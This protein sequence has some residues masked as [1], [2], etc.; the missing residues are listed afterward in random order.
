MRKIKLTQK[1][2]VQ[3]CV[4]AGLFFMLLFFAISQKISLGQKYQKIYFN[5]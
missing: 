5:G 1:V 2:I 3:L 4:I